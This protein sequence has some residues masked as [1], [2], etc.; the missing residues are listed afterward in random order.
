MK[1]FLIAI[2]L[3]AVTTSARADI[4]CKFG[5]SLFGWSDGEFI[6]QFGMADDNSAWSGEYDVSHTN[7]S[8]LGVWNYTIAGESWQFVANDGTMAIRFARNTDNTLKEASRARP[9]TRARG[10]GKDEPLVRRNNLQIRVTG[11][12]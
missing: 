7:G 3:C 1:W 11:D 9:A 12:C 10:A 6:L 5:P 8:D 4:R 2:A